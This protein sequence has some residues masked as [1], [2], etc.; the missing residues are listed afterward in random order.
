MPSNGPSS[1]GVA[2]PIRILRAERERLKKEHAQGLT[3][4]KLVQALTAAMDA[5]VRAVWSE[6]VDVPDRIALVA[7]GGYGREELAPH[8]DVDLMVL[9]SARS[10]APDVGK[11]LFYQLWDAGFAVGHA[12]RTVKDCLR[13]AAS[14]V[15]AETSFLDSRFVDGDET[16]FEDFRAAT[17]KQTRKRGARLVETLRAATAARHAK[18]GSASYFL[19][20][21]IKEGAGGLR[22][23][24]TIGWLATAFD[25]ESGLAADPELESAT[26]VLLRVRTELHY[27]T[28]RRADLLTLHTQDAMAEGLGYAGVDVFLRELYAGARYIEYS[29]RSA[30]AEVAGRVARRSAPVRDVAPGIELSSSGIRI[31]DRRPIVDV[32]EL[33]MRAFA[34]AAAEGVPI[35]TETMLWL[36]S[37]A[38]AADLEWNDASRR[39]FFDILGRGRRGRDAL[40]AMDH[41]GIL[42]R[43][44]PDWEAVRCLPQHNVYHRFTVDVH[45]LTTVLE[46]CRLDGPASDD[47]DALARDVWCDLADRNRVLLACLLHDIGKGREDDHSILGETL[48]ERICA[49]MGLSPE[50]A[51]DVVWLVRHHLLLSDTAIRRDTGDENLVVETAAWIGNAERLK[52]LYVLSVADGRATGPA[53]WNPWKATLVGELF[54][55]VLRV[56]EEGRLV[57]ADVSDLVRLRGTELRAAL[58]RYLPDAVEAHLA[59][60]PRAYFLAFPTEALIRHFALMASAP[61]GGAVSIHV[62][63]TEAPGVYELDVVAPDRPGLFSKVAGGLALNGINVLSAQ[64]FTRGDG[65]ALEVFRVSGAHEDEVDPG[66]WDRVRS[67]ISAAITDR[68]SLDERLAQ[69]REVYTR[70]SKGKR[71]S[72]RVLVENAA[73]D[74][75][76]VV[77]VHATDRVGLLYAITDA[78]AD[79]EL[80]IHSA[81]VAT[82]GE[83]VVDVFYVRDVVAQKIT[84]PKRIREIERVVL[85][86]IGA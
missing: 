63:K 79:L 36:R 12:I 76:T 74:F 6:A 31:F 42:V 49:R 58:T 38:P 52:M 59:G 39:S 9:H 5:A 51:E 32:P 73:S 60:M 23:R 15:E 21:N 62:A 45:L 26:D 72:P 14:N 65:A 37:A 4:R 47:P 66:R 57:G 55:K 2:E 29:M 24:A 80:D 83:D 78:L 3:G 82:Y 20:P 34:I 1:G 8:S 53:A 81:R 35:S 19:E 71:E 48:A 18:E 68:L 84:D 11:R 17:L 7:L 56:I 75:F 22:D 86:R 41:A 64:I 16:L 44:L 67:D 61:D 13:L 50:V 70:P 46:A 10:I 85:E 33:P 69:K 27:T 30:L 43:Y 25:T 54:S 77:E 28:D 40:E